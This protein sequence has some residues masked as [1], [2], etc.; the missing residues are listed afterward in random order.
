MSF[1]IK[2][3]VSGSL[4]VL[5]GCSTYAVAG[6]NQTVLVGYFE[7]GAIPGRFV[8]ED[9]VGGSWLLINYYSPTLKRVLTYSVAKFD[10]CSAVAMC[11]VK[12][13]RQVA[14][15]GS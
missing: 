3:L 4:Y 5:V 6:G 2:I 14:I 12:N 9:N 11:K 13:S 8:Y 7:G 15:D 10:E 1:F